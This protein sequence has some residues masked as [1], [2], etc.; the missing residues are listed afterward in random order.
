MDR[1]DLDLHTSIQRN[2]DEL[3]C[4]LDQNEF[5]EADTESFASGRTPVKVLFNKPGFWMSLHFVAMK[6]TKPWSLK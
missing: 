6:L 5:D 1:I 4:L 2:L 3:R